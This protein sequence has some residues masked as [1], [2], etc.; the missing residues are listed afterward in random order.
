ML[1]CKE[2]T[3]LM[4]EG[5]DRKLGTGEQLQLHL[6]LAMCSGCRNFREQMDFLRTACRGFLGRVEADEEQPPK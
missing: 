3:H 4:S 2:A 1:S 5:L 6:H